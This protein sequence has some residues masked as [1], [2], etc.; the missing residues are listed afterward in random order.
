[1]SAKFKMDRTIGRG[2]SFDVAKDHVTYWND[3]SPN[4]RLE[5]AWYL[6]G[7]TYGVDSKTR[8]AR[9]VFSKRKHES[10]V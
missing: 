5:A 4:E 10:A 8:L 1:M 9:K 2:V 3:K 7:I 6:I